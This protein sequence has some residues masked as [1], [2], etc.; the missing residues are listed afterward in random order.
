MKDSFCT[1]VRSVR[2]EVVCGAIKEGDSL[3][4]EIPDQLIK[5]EP[6]TL[7]WADQAAGC[8]LVYKLY[9]F[10]SAFAWQREQHSRFRV[11]REFDNLSI[12]TRAGV[13]CTEPAFWSVGK[14]PK[15]GR[16]EILATVEIPDARSFK[17]ICV[18]DRKIAERMDWQPL[19]QNVRKMHQSGL[20]HGALNPRNIL[21][22]GFP[23]NVLFH[24]IDLPSAIHFPFDLRS[25]KMG[26]FDLLHFNKSFARHLDVSVPLGILDD[27]DFSEDEKARFLGQLEQYKSSKHLRNRLRGEFKFRAFWARLRNH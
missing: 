14:T 11:Q 10:R 18:Q 21:L 8:R 13:G 26:W 25:T 27:Y 16:F 20:Y 3:T 4:F 24:I 23:E 5:E 2:D 22:S 12:L 1:L 6:D 9:R 17:E 15:H 19:F 7:I